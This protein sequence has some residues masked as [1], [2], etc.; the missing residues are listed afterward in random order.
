MK[1]FTKFLSILVLAIVC[2]FSVLG[3][4]PVTSPSFGNACLTTADVSWT[5]PG[6]V[7]TILVFAKAGSAVTVGTPTSDIAV[8]YPTASANFS[9]P[10]SPYQNDASAFLVYKNTSGTSVSVTGLTAG[11]TYHF[12]IFNANGTSYSAAA[13]VFGSTLS[14]PGNASS[15]AA[16]IPTNASVGLSWTDPV[17]CF[18]EVLIIGK[19]TSVTGSPT[20]GAAAY[21]TANVNF[22][23]AIAPDF[24]AGAKV[25][26][27]GTNATPTIT[28]L[29]GGTTYFFKIFTRQATTWSSGVEISTTTLPSPA[30]GG[31]FTSSCVDIGTVSWTNPTPIN[32]ILVF[33]KAGSAINVGTPTVDISTYITASTNLL[34]PGTA[35]ENDAA[36][37]LVFKNTSGASANL[38][39]LA[40]GTTY[41]FLVLNANGTSY[42][43]S[44]TFNNSTLAAPPEITAYAATPQDGSIDLNWTNP[45]CADNILIVA[46]LGSAIT[47]TPTGSTYTGNLNFGTATNGTGFAAS[48]KI[49]YFGTTPPI[50]V[51]NLTNGS[52]YHFKAFTVKGST[53]AAGTEITSSPIDLTPPV[54]TT[55]D[56][57]DDAI[58]VATDETFSITFSEN[59]VISSAASVVANDDKIRI[60][61]GGGPTTELTIDRSSVT[62]VGNVAT[63]TLS[64][65]LTQFNTAYHVRIGD[66]VFADGSGNA[67]AGITNTT[68]WSFTTT[69]GVTVTQPTTLNACSNAGFFPL[70][71]ILIVENG[72][73]DFNGNSVTRTLVL[74][75]DQG[76]F[77]FQPGQGNAVIEA[78]TGTDLTINS[79]SVSFSAVTIT[80]TSDGNQNRKERMRISGLR[81]QSDGTA[82]TPPGHVVRTGGSGI[83]TGNAV[84]DNRFHGTITIGT[85]SATPVVSFSPTL[86]IC[87]NS[88]IAAGP[89]VTSNNTNVKWFRDAALTDEI[90][91]IAG[92]TNPTPAQVEFLTAT[93]GTITR[94][95]TQNST[96]CQSSAVAL[97]TTVQPKPVADIVITSGSS[98]LCVGRN[99]QE[100]VNFGGSISIPSY[101][102]TLVYDNV[103]FTASP[104]GAANYNFRRNGISVQNSASNQYTT[105]SQFLNTGDNLDVIVSVPG[106]CPSTS[107]T[108]PMTV[109]KNLTNTNFKITFPPPPA[110][111]PDSLNT[112]SS[113]LDTVR[114]KPQPPGGVFSGPGITKRGGLDY[115]GA[116]L[117]GQD[118]NPYFI[119]YTTSLNGCESKRTRAFFVFDGSTAIS[120]LN[121]VYCSNDSDIVLA[122]NS[123]PGYTLMYILPQNFYSSPL[124]PTGSITNGGGNVNGPNQSAWWNGT[125]TTTNAPFT[126]RPN[127]VTANGTNTVTVTFYAYYVNNITSV[128]ETRTQIVT[129][130]PAPVRPTLSVSTPGVSSLCS[131]DA[132]LTSY[133]VLVGTSN[134]IATIRWFRTFAPFGEI[135]AIGDKARPTFSELGVA[136]GAA[137]VYTY[138]VTQTVS[139][140]QGP[141][142]ALTI[143]VNS[144]PTPPI[145]TA[146]APATFCSGLPI[147]NFS[148]TGTAVRWYNASNLTGEYSPIA[149][150]GA[151]QA[152][153]VELGIPSS[154]SVITNI[155][156]YATQTANGCQSAPASASITVNPIPLA[157]AA[158]APT[159]CKNATIPDFTASPIGGATVRWYRNASLTNQVLPIANSSSPTPTEMG[160]SSTAPVLTSFYVTQSIGGCVSPTTRVDFR[161]N[162]LPTVSFTT[163]PPLCKTSSTINLVATAING[164][165]SGGL[166]TQSAA[167]ALSGVNSP[168][169]TA[170]LDPANSNLQAGQTYQLRYSVTDASSCS[171]FFEQSVVM[172]PS[173]TPSI[174]IANACEGTNF[175]IQNTSTILPTS[176]SSNI[177]SYGWSFVGRDNISP[178]RAPLLS[179]DPIS[180]ATVGG[181]YRNPVYSYPTAGTYQVQYTMIT[182]NNCVVTQ[183]QLINVGTTPEFDLTWHNPCQPGGVQ[184]Q[185]NVTGG[186]YAANELTYAWNF[187]KNGAL[188]PTGGNPLNANPLV[189]YTNLGKDVAEL[190]VTGTKAQQPNIGAPNTVCIN[191][192]SKNIFVVPQLPASSTNP[193]N[194]YFETSNGDWVSGGANSSWSWMTAP[195]TGSIN[196]NGPASP[197]TKIWKTHNGSG[198]YNA[199]ER[200]FI[201]SPCVNLS[202]GNFTKPVLSFDIIASTPSTSVDGLVVQWTNSDDIENNANWNVLGN[203]S[204]GKNWYNTSII[205]SSPFTPP[206]GVSDRPQWLRAS[207]PLDAQIGALNSKVKFRVVFTS[208][209]DG[210]R[211]NNVGVAIDNVFIGDRTRITLIENFTNTSLKADPAAKN[212]NSVYNTFGT[213]GAE[214]VRLQYHTG[215]P[216]A[217][218]VNTEFAGIHNPRASFYGIDNSPTAR[219]DGAFESGPFGSWA[220]SVYNDRI[221]EP[222]S[223]RIL[224]PLYTLD[225]TTGAVKIKPSFTTTSNL[226][227]GT[228]IFTVLAEKTMNDPRYRGQNGEQ[229][230]NYVVKNIFPSPAGYRLPND[231]IASSSSP[232]T[233]ALPEYEWADQGKLLTPGNGAIV[234]F[235]QNDSGPNLAK[236]V[237][238]AYVDNNPL[239]PSVITAIE[240]D[241][242]SPLSFYPVPADKE[243]LISLGEAALTNTPVVMYDA[244]GKSV[245]QTMIDKGQQTKTVSTQDFAPGVYIIQ[246][247]TDK[248]TV[249][250]KV[251]VV[252]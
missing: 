164:D 84:V 62:V 1:N 79:I 120:G 77:V 119:S 154:I 169:G 160:V 250:K 85:A 66:K 32:T 138:N 91:A 244:L 90:I 24:D 238:Q 195:N 72:N 65:A 163:I 156:R 81:I 101:A 225:A 97:S 98:T 110:T 68:D 116:S 96:G 187:A 143:T 130:I 50:T 140:C 115:F 198:N 221:L 249:R 6:T 179:T 233:I 12:L 165:L 173:V 80:Y 246:L 59:V 46:K 5:N 153:S 10:G 141:P 211:G 61:Y 231:V 186:G 199:Q 107:N 93:P 131:A 232:A 207:Y 176:S 111:T 161:V 37:F 51:T 30:T 28:N 58:N 218:P 157:L 26:Y 4:S 117:V 150:A 149:A 239:H 213:I 170:T 54:I 49:V 122:S 148:S 40:A 203:N 227:K 205:S 118:P 133:E 70:G 190:T 236:Q 39:G 216:G 125:F 134:P 166:W 127:N 7:N 151:S 27:K 99:I 162:D 182:S 235:L 223:V 86:P 142:R 38:T 247:E 67:F 172:L 230:F 245:H 242:V 42:S 192:K 240:P 219:I 184:F 174:S 123:R 121:T 228:Y 177:V 34:S 17:T 201:L 15:F 75:F 215:F 178:N 113:Q 159:V 106:S 112:F 168:P 53:W 78:I 226:Q 43:A 48:E 114:L 241:M 129:F 35:Y 145:V 76:G 175:T 144:T 55:T 194:Q 36:A 222:T 155:T 237:L 29:T 16:G 158:T 196:S 104:T 94:Y 95:V 146:P 45:S 82:P 183:T 180:S 14:T 8:A 13:T 18:D 202:N 20:G 21:P 47:G 185:T 33:A 52:T 243:L 102:S 214:A 224:Q 69:N 128:A 191:T 57:V 44:L 209:L 92:V 229:S 109:N 73:S 23:A 22:S 206:N 9:S 234:V 71:D 124:L 139:G 193:Y 108:I 3:Q 11:T 167:I 189:N 212:Q 208:G 126:I 74:G 103:A 181:T 60:R 210:A 188:S 41:H 87:Q 2:S 19:T 63:F 220:Q 100:I 89:N 132:N 200:S 252:H 64:P 31:T 217:D 251:M 147:G 25:L 171:N 197:G 137:G 204:S 88:V 136:T 152:T 83:I 56:P 105:S 248:G 135:T